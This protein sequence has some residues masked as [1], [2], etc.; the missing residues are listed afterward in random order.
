[1]PSSFAVL[2]LF[3]VFAQSPPAPSDALL[4][5]ARTGDR[6]RVAA[7][8]DGGADVNAVSRY[9]VSALGFAAERGHFEI[10]RLLVERGAN[11]NIAESFYGFRPVDFALRG[12][13]LD[14]AVLLLERGALGAVGVLN[15]GIRA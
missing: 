3:T 9:N 15:A 8:L 4:E 10:V 7:L 11:V 6:A 5:A 1:M 13:R 12:G 2:M 14:I